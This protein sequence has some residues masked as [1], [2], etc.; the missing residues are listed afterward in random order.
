MEVYLCTFADSRMPQ[1][2][3]RVGRQAVESGFFK[4]V[5]LYDE[6]SFSESFKKQFA[7]QLQRGV[8]G[9]G[10]WVWKPYV[11]LETL[12]KIPEQSILLYMD[13]GCHI[14][15][16]GREQLR[17]WVERTAV[18]ESGMLVADL[19]ES[20]L[21]SY[22]TKGDLLDFFGIR[23]CPEL[24]LAP[25]RAATVFLLR[26]EE[27]SIQLIRDWLSV[28]ETR[29]SLVD[30]TP[31]QSP[32]LSG[33]IENRHDQSVFSILT[34]LRGIDVFPFVDLE[35][36]EKSPILPLR[37]KKLKLRYRY[38]LRRFLSKCWNKLRHSLWKDRTGN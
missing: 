32:N 10:Y 37:D 3:K 18:S 31:S 5:Y 26:K 14:N 8:R 13:A 21:E 4:D 36:Q 17:E 24:C 25:Q 27:K 12:R 34:K 29:F 1:T 20:C 33:F 2:L 7:Q 23:D 11:V 9:F 38:S 22:Y 15:P 30:D 28:F 6:H 16:R 19:G 35:N